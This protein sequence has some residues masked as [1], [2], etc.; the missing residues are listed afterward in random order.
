M[1]HQQNWP[2]VE[3]HLPVRTCDSLWSWDV[4]QVTPTVNR[5]YTTRRV[6]QL[7]ALLED[8]LSEE[9][10]PAT[11]NR[12]IKRCHGKSDSAKR[13]SLAGIRSLNLR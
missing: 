2:F 3:L 6:R 7:G 9:V 12:R 13:I 4:V 10:E 11:A 1:I 5:E 8:L